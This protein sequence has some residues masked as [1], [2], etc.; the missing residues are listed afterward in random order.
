MCFL[1]VLKPLRQ[2][3]ALQ[4][5]FACKKNDFVKI[6]LSGAG[7]EV[8]SAPQKFCFIENLDKIPENLG[9]TSENLG[10]MPENPGKMAPNICRKTQSRP[11]FGG[12]TK[13]RSSCSLWEKICGQKSFSGKFGEIRAKILCT[14]KTLPA[15]SPMTLTANL[16][17]L[18]H[19]QEGWR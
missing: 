14:P 10:K 15:P 5:K 17:F 8:A 12:H 4:R 9:K 16:D 6:N 3:N 1:E 11:F 19:K 13:I 7:S 2:N 18:C